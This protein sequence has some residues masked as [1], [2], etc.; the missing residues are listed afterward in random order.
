MAYWPLIT[1]WFYE[2]KEIIVSSVSLL[3]KMNCDYQQMCTFNIEVNKCRS[4]VPD[5]Q[6]KKLLCLIP[7][8]PLMN[9]MLTTAIYVA[10]SR[11]ISCSL[12]SVRRKNETQQISF[13]FLYICAGFSQIIWI[14][15]HFEIHVYSH[16][17]G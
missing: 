2:N 9:F 3:K 11:L 14:D 16:E 1:M 6:P 15:K 10:V 17:R 12:P 7:G 13:L 8:Y 5:G 4:G